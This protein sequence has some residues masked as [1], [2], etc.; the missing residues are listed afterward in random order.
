MEA[1]L[2]V[3]MLPSLPPPPPL[4]PPL[5][6]SAL[7]QLLLPKLFLAPNGARRQALFLLHMAGAAMAPLLP[8]LLPLR[9]LPR[10][11]SLK[12]KK[13]PPPAPSGSAEEGSPAV[14]QE[15]TEP[16]QADCNGPKESTARRTSS[17][18]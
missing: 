10:R 13:L 12:G 1:A 8:P 16:A 6:A 5:A 15:A 18:G 17:S 2:A 14:E 4:R 3:A 9:V 7:W 11:W